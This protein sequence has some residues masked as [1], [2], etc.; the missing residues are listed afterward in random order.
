M[1]LSIT[2]FFAASFL[3][4][5]DDLPLVHYYAKD[6]AFHITMGFPFTYHHEFMMRGSLV[7]DT[8]NSFI[9]LL[10]DAGL[11]FVVVVGSY[12]LVQRKKTQANTVSKIQ[13]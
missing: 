12:L 6:E 11:T 7:P 3:T 4:L 10:V 13:E 8:E 9:N 2:I 5:L 1:L